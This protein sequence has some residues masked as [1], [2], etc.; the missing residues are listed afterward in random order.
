MFFSHTSTDRISHLH[1]LM[2]IQDPTDTTCCTCQHHTIFPFLTHY[3]FLIIGDNMLF[4][5][6]V[7]AQYQIKFDPFCL[8]WSFIPSTGHAAGKGQSKGSNSVAG[9]TDQTLSSTVPWLIKCFQCVIIIIYLLYAV[10]DIADIDTAR[11]REPYCTD[12][13]KGVVFCFGRVET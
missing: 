3:F 13:C 4:F 10:F 11:A 7:M 8:H 12:D 9:K 6:Q 1:I 2:L 5:C